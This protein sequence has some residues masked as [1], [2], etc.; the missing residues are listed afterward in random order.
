MRDKALTVLRKVATPSNLRFGPPLRC[1]PV[2]LHWHYPGQ[3]VRVAA[4]ATLSLRG[5]KNASPNPLTPLTGYPSERALRE[6]PWGQYLSIALWGR[7]A[8]GEF[9][10]LAFEI[11]DLSFKMGKEEHD[12]KEGDVSRQYVA[13]GWTQGSRGGV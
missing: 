3:V 11:P 12:R 13:R 2:S 5:V 6:I 1:P 9:L 4:S 8:I 7:T 10:I